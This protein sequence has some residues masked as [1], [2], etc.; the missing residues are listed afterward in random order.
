MHESGRRMVADGRGVIVVQNDMD[1]DMLPYLGGLK[2]PAQC[3]KFSTNPM[4]VHV[5]P[6]D[7]RGGHKVLFPCPT[8]SHRPAKL[9]M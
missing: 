7:G 5:I 1:F 6:R 8:L 3:I 4:K 9:L 2:G